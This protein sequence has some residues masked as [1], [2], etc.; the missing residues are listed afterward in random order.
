M[1]GCTDEVAS[2]IALVVL[3]CERL[4]D[5]NG[6]GIAKKLEAEV[7][8]ELGNDRRLSGDGFRIF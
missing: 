6:L 5:A 4:T 7:A 2:V 8:R 1:P 3:E